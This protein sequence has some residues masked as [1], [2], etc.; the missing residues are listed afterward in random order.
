MFGAEIPDKDSFITDFANMIICMFEEYAQEGGNGYILSPIH[1]DINADRIRRLVYFY[2]KMMTPEDV[3]K[4]NS[5]LLLN[6]EHAGK[7][8]KD[9]L[10]S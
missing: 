3:I 7:K 4:L 5:R 6:K 9:V 1:S 8:Y 2:F 10:N